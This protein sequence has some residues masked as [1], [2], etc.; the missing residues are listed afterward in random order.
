MS[1]HN[2][3]DDERVDIT[4]KFY[5]EIA[6]K[7]KKLDARLGTVNCRF[8]GEKFKKWNI[9][10]GSAGSDFKIIDFYYDEESSETDLGL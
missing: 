7:L 10:F 9:Q 2:L 5:E 4:E 1:T 6:P 8:A 3:D